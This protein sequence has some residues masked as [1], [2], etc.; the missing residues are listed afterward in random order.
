[1]KLEKKNSKEAPSLPKFV[2]DSEKRK[3]GGWLLMFFSEKKCLQI[4]FF[5]L[6]HIDFSC[7]SFINYYLLSLDFPILLIK[8]RTPHT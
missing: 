5:T 4:F 8:F 3:V 2:E 6:C 1:M 7:I